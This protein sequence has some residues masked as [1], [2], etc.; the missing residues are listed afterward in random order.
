[1]RRFYRNVDVAESEDGLALLLDGKPVKTPAGNRFCLPGRAAAQAAAAEWAA[2]GE[3][4]EPADMPVTRFA[5]SVI[6]G[7]L[8]RRKEVAET[9]VSYAATDLL[10]YRTAAAEDAELAAAQRRLWDPPLDWIAEAESI[11]LAVTQGLRPA[12]QDP[13]AIATLRSLL[14]DF[15]AWRLAG[16]HTAATVTG[17]AVLAIALER[18]AFALERIWQAAILE[19]THQIARWGDDAEAAKR[20]EGL[21]QE[22]EEAAAWLALLG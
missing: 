5:N 7:V 18:K 17:S 8:N 4:V 16:V 12:S 2:Q 1:V 3:S 22:L 15:D 14:G 20:R 19:E 10:C 9:V 21:R 6:D 13:A 11:R